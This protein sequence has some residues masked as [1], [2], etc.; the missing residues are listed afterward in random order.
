MN[1]EQYKAM[2]PRILNAQRLALE[3]VE[4]GYS[5]VGVA[6]GVAAMKALK[7]KP[8]KAAASASEL[9]KAAAPKAGK[10]A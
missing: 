3:L 5:N 6:L 9:P 8:T 2:Q 7:I 1:L 10:G 4:L